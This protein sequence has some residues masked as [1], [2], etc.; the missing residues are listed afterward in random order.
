MKHTVFDRLECQLG[1]GPFWHPERQ[2]LS[3]C[4]NLYR[5]LLSSS[6]EWDSPRAASAAGW[7][8]KS[9]LLLASSS[10]LEVFDLATGCCELIEAVEAENPQTLFNDGR[11]DPMGGFW[12]LTMGWD[13][14][15]K[16]GL[17]YRYADGEL[18]KFVE[19]VTIPN[20]ICFS[21]CGGWVYF[22]DTPTQKII[23]QE[24]YPL[25]GWPFQ[26]ATLFVDL[27]AKG[28]NPDG[29]SAES[30]GNFWV[31][32]WGSSELL[33]FSPV[34]VEFGKIILPTP[35]MDCPA[36]GAAGSSVIFVTTA[37]FG[38]LQDAGTQEDPLGK[39]FFIKDAFQSHSNV[40][41]KIDAP[42]SDLT[43]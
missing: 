3:W 4:D 34:G 1:E 18:R 12:F 20:A 2:E 32:M 19:C 30:T 6:N 21:S 36:P 24:L 38:M 43:A 27:S 14:Q 28:Q 16:D 7:I 10:G 42:T 25:T 11:L 22:A 15:T 31:A 26:I 5:K 41:V 35:N 13:A 17:I 40:P 33:G 39:T 9:T 8:D 37:L 23:R 29:A